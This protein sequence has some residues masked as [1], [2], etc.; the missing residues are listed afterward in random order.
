MALARNASDGVHSGQDK[1]QS[2][3]IGTFT[4]W[5][6]SYLE[7]RGYPVT[8]LCAQIQD[9]VIAFRLLEALEGFPAAPVHRG[10]IKTTIG[11]S[12]MI[13]ED[14]SPGI[15]RIF[16]NCIQAMAEGE[17]LQLER[18]FDVDVPESHYYRVIERKSATLLGAACECGAVVAGVTRAEERR[19]AEFGRELGLAFQIRDDALDYEA[20]ERDFGKHRYTDLREGKVTLPLLFA[21]KRCTT[22]EREMAAGLLKS[23]SAE[24]LEHGESQRPAEE[25]EPLLDL[26][27]RYRGI[28]DAA[29]RADEHVAR[30]TA[31]IAPFEDGS[32]KQA[33]LSAAAFA[34]SRDR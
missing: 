34:V 14:G 31:A 26:V 13:V 27:R 20:D 30:A 4:R 24:A 1:L 8:D 19:V 15:L 6:N 22:A 9:G 21:L 12:T 28:E 10:K 7:P 17:L 32:P 18:S 33:L 23:L 29:R 25:I 11:A 2:Q 16:T 3:Q 5:W